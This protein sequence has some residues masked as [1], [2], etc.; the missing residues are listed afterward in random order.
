MN[1]QIMKPY[2]SY[3]KIVSLGSLTLLIHSVTMAG[4]TNVNIEPLAFNPDNVTINV[5]DQV[6][7]TWVSDF[8]TTTSD[9][10]LL[11]FGG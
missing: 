6:V 8:H 7:W 5:N 2:I 1:A 10:G 9:S 3:R 11:G 4:I